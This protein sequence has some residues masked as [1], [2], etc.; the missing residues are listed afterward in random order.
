MFDPNSGAK[1]VKVTYNVTTGKYFQGKYTFGEV[2]KADRRYYLF[3]LIFVTQYM[4][5]IS[6]LS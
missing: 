5:F 4:E 6:F 3:L 2:Y 1:N